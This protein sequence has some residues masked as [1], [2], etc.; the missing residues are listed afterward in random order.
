MWGKRDVD[1]QAP[2]F[3]KKKAKME[4]IRRWGKRSLIDRFASQEDRKLRGMWGKRNAVSNPAWPLGIGS[5]SPIKSL[6]ILTKVH[7]Q[8]KWMQLKGCIMRTLS[9]LLNLSFK[10]WVCGASG[11]KT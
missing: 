1:V 6:A 8:P 10:G 11:V 3:P 4:E 9:G 2:A 7:Q 5:N